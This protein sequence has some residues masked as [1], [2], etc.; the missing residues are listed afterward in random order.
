MNELT[1]VLAEAL[2]AGAPQDVLVIGCGIG[3]FARQLSLMGHRVWACQE[4]LAL[5]LQLQ[6]QERQWASEVEFFTADSLD[7]QPFS[8]GFFDVVVVK[9]EIGHTED[10]VGL[11][12]EARRV[13]R[14][15]GVVAGTHLLQGHSARRQR[16]LFDGTALW[17]FTM[18]L[19][20][21]WAG[22]EVRRRETGFAFWFNVAGGSR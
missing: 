15:G 13:T 19:T 18:R 10:V 20:R 14:E 7:M 12:E 21:G 17:G 6:R 4:S 3:R 8:D 9:E 22:G 16:W 5:T 1:K 2:F 11:F